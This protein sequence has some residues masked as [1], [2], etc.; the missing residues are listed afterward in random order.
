MDIESLEKRNDASIDALESKTALLKSITS[1]IRGEVVK[2]HD[3][4]DS[5]SKGM[6]G[7]QGGIGSAATKMKRVM[8]SPYGRQYVYGVLAGAILLYVLYY[9]VL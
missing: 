1:G 3:I 8:E 6:H 7:V 4:L 2:H 5:M 9:H